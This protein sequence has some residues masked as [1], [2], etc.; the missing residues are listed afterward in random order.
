VL[1]NVIHWLSLTSIVVIAALF[2]ITLVD[3]PSFHESAYAQEQGQNV[4]LT[5]IFNEFNEKGMVNLW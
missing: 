3:F 2:A 1:K 5:V 4:T